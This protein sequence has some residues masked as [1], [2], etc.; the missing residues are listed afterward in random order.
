MYWAHDFADRAQTG[1]FMAMLDD[2]AEPDGRPPVR[3]AVSDDIAALVAD[4][5]HDRAGWLAQAQ[6]VELVS[7][8]AA[9]EAAE[10]A[11]ERMLDCAG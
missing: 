11:L 9:L 4:S 3:L 6:T 8:P 2:D 10:R 5:A 7:A 1:W